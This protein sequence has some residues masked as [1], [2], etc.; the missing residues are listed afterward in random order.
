MWWDGARWHAQAPGPAMAPYRPLAGLSVVVQAGLAL[1]VVVSCFTIWNDSRRRA[2]VD[3]FLDGTV[4]FSELDAADD[5]AA[6]LAG[7]GLVVMALIIVALLVWRYRVQRNLRDA[8]AVRS[9]EYSPGWAVGWWFVPIANLFKPKQAMNEAWLASDP[10]APAW[11]PSG[12]RGK[13]PSLLSWWWAAWL[14]SNFTDGVST[15][16]SST[17]VTLDS[18]RAAMSMSVFSE[19]LSIVA[20]LLLISIVRQIGTRQ[21]QRARALGVQVA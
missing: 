16:G 3:G 15:S 5:T 10:S 13:A 9:L 14:L 7:A 4:T 6:V 17:D 12:R 8:L 1:S 19:L 18:F 2:M 11:S 21:A 20:A